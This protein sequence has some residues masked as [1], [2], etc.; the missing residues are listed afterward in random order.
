GLAPVR[1]ADGPGRCA[2]RVEVFHEEKW[3]T[4]CD[5]TWDFLDAKVVC[6]Q[7]GCGTVLSAP[8][9]ARFGPGE[10]P[11][12]L[13]DVRCQGTEAA[14]SECRNKGWGGRGCNH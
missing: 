14:L 7:L 8:R 6:R 9:R 5:D 10:G 3:G 2:G 4:V 1:L 11:V 12:W 13:Q